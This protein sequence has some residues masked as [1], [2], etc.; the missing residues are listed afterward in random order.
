M[1][2]GLP[3]CDHYEGRVAVNKKFRWQ[4]G[5]IVLLASLAMTP[6]YAA[7]AHPYLNAKC[8]PPVASQLASGHTIGWASV[9]VKL[10][11]PLT[12]GEN[13][14]LSSLKV[15]IYRHLPLIESVAMRVPV[16]NLSTLASLPFAKHISYDGEVVKNDEFTFDNSGGQAAYE[17]YGLTGAG[18]GV[19]VLDTGVHFDNDFAQTTQGGPSRIVANVV[20]STTCTDDFCGHGT[21][22]AGIIAGN[23]AASTVTSAS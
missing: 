16:R 6:N 15:D 10:D 17:Q 12:A 23:G 13:S 3:N 11:G 21:H 9:I 7:A 14:K 1:A 2:A 19:A 22:V 8:D 5:A 20:F 18:V 4:W